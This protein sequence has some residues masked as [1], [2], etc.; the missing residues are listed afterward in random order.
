MTRMDIKS[1]IRFG[2]E[3]FETSWA[4]Q[5]MHVLPASPEI[6][7]ILPLAGG[8]ALFFFAVGSQLPRI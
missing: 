5:P 7:K 6:P 1:P 3:E 8:F 2:K 4:E